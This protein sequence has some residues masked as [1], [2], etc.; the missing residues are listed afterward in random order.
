MSNLTVRANSL[1]TGTVILESPNTNSNRTITLPDATT[2]LVGTNATQT[3]TNKTIQSST[4]Q[5]GALTMMTFVAAT[6]TAVDF[7]GIPDWVKRITIVIYRVSTNG[8]SNLLV[9]IGSTTFTTSGYEA[10]VTLGGGNGSSTAGFILSQTNAG[11]YSSSGTVVL[12]KLTG[13]TW[14]SAGTL[15]V[16]GSFCN[17]SGGSLPLGGVLDRVRITTVNGTDAFD[18]GNFNVLYEG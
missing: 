8:T 9:Q 17:V 13:N 1:G 2:T 7:T 11:T 3:L 16:A 15:G 12:T 10:G 5:G 14:I 6:S 18:N 4:L